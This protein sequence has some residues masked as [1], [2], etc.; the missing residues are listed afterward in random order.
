MATK[1]VLRPSAPSNLLLI[2]LVVTLLV[3]CD[4][5]PT[6]EVT[7]AAATTERLPVTLT[8]APT[9]S[10]TP[11]PSRT[12]LIPTW[13]PAPTWP[14]GAGPKIYVAQAGDTLQALAER[15]KLEL[16]A[17]AAANVLGEG[18]QIQAGQSLIIPPERGAGS[19][20]TVTLHPED[21]AL[22]GTSS[23][24]VSKH[25]LGLSTQGRPIEA[26][27]IGNG[28]IRIAF[29]GG[30]HGGYEWN[31]ILLAYRAIDY[32][33][34]HPDEVVDGISLIIVPAAN[35]DGQHAVVGHDGR[36]SPDEV[37][38]D[39]LPG[40]FNGNGVDLNRNWACDWAPTAFLGE[41]EISAGLRPFSEVETRILRFFL[42]NP[43]MDAVIFWHS[44]KPGVF[45]GACGEPLPDAEALAAIYAQAADYPLFDGFDD[46]P[47][48]GDASDWLSG[49]GIPAITVELSSHTGTDWPQNLAAIRAVL[50]LF[51]GS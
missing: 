34:A 48:T 13:T 26:Y 18:D 47:V 25:Q 23:T 38:A 33:A 8:L 11:S 24:L 46:Y 40:R 29:I 20:A 45:A 7:G 37:A 30:I 27:Q 5:P 12:P 14:P 2:A 19:S 9:A 15:F 31:T 22:V 32:F 28:E 6:Y 16:A 4:L 1:R 49:I 41:Q 51:A 43:N 50:G 21:S 17:L 10:M 35:P 36:F 42:T 3:G 39:S 44:A